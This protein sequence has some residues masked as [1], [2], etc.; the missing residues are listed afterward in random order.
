MATK[1]FV[2]RLLRNPAEAEVDRFL[3][4]RSGR[5]MVQL[6]RLIPEPAAQAALT[7]RLLLLAPPAMSGRRRFIVPEKAKKALNAFVGFR[8]KYTTPHYSDPNLSL[9]ATIS[10]S[11]ISSHG[12]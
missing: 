2:A 4:S 7:A 8:C 10:R 6:F 3:Q 12:P 9:Q 5:Q 11:L 1:D